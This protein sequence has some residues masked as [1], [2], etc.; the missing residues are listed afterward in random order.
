MD[1]RVFRLAV[2]TMISAF[3]L[4]LVI[5]YATNAKQINDLL[6]IGKKQADTADTAADTGA[7]D[8]MAELSKE[9]PFYGDQIGDDLDGFTMDDGF[10][11]E[12]EQVPT[13]VVIQRKTSDSSAMGSTES[14]SDYVKDAPADDA[15]G[16]VSSDQDTAVQDDTQG[17]G[18]AVV[19]Q[20][21]N[22]NPEPE[23]AAA[24]SSG[25]LTS[26]PDPPPGGFGQYIPA[27]ETIGGTP[28]GDVP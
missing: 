9:E 23:T 27:G 26:L 6:G 14:I 19:G 16:G 17:T 15:S 13:V 2:L 1:K 12:T 22:P 4:V 20:L 5:V 10:F 24:D 18:M 8:E 3:I 11:D 25:Y 21:I 28:V 7:L